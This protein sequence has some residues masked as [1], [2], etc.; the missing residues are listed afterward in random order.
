MLSI[1]QI[2]MNL[3]FLNYY[4]DRI[5]G[6]KGNNTINA[7]KN[8][9]KDN[10]L[11]VDGIYGV[12]TEET[13]VSMIKQIQEIV[14][15]EVDG[16]AGKN[17][18]EKTKEYQSKNGLKVDGIAGEQTRN[19]MFQETQITWNDIKYFNQSEFTCKDGCGFD[20]INIKLVKILDEMRE[21]YGRPIIITSGCRCKKH[22]RE[23]QGADT[24]R[25]VYGK[26]ADLYVQGVNVNDFLIYA[27]DLV[28]RG[29]LR[30]TYTNN[31]N[32]NGVIHIDIQ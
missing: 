15:T 23:V 20:N 26:A 27:K 11:V 5:D 13:L 24:S 29:I 30:Y 22:N 14:R 9:Q 10:G 1:K 4:Y 31:S 16:V 18:I 3:K 8:F 32:M 17:T 12:Q 21:Y 6:I 2:Q 28:R 25:H 7:I 19:H